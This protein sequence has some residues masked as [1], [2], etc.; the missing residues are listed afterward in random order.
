MH[1][2]EDVGVLRFQTGHHF[3]RAH[4]HRPGAKEGR[5][6]TKEGRKEYQVRKEG[7]KAGRKEG[8]KGK[9]VPTRW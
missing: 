6:D 9:G 8:R 1:L 2:K 5:K 7:R 3:R 4:V